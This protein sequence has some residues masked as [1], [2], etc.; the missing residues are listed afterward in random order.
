MKKIFWLYFSLKGRTGRASYLFLFLL[1]SIAIG[2]LSFKLADMFNAKNIIEP[3]I[4]YGFIWPAVAV[5]IKR[6][7]DLNLSGWWLLA[8]AIPYIGFLGSII[9]FGFVP[10][11]SNENRF[12]LS[13]RWAS[14]T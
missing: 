10:G 8:T 12:G 7:H 11:S 3:I 5:Q 14:N 13:H 6:L 9:V 2:L 1:P 4:T